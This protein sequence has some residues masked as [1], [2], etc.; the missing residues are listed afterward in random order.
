MFNEGKATEAEI[1]RMF[2]FSRQRAHQIVRGYYSYKPR[3]KESCA[4]LP[5]DNN[6]GQEYNEEKVVS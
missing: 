3:Q 2:N 5:L 6:S 4:K 1:A